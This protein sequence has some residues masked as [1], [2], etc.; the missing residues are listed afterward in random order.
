[1]NRAFVD[2]SAILAYLAPTDQHHE[3]ALTDF[4]RLRVARSALITTSYVLLETYAL[5]LRR[6]G[7][8]AVS[9]F[10]RDFAPSLEIVWIDADL[11]ERGLD[12]VIER[13]SRALGLVDAVSFVVMRDLGLEVAFAFDS[14]FVSE[15]FTLVRDLP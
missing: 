13:G 3:G 11:H 6:H 4:G 9:D 12:I 2:T 8:G 15:G 14:D 7:I 5:L 10:R 1:M